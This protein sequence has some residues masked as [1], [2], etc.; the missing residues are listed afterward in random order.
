MADYAPN[1]TPRYRVRYKVG[2]R[3]HSFTWRVQRGL[4]A[5]DAA[6]SLAN[7]ASAFFNALRDI[8]YANFAILGAD[9]AET[10]SDIFL[11]TIAPTVDIGGPSDIGSSTTKFITQ[12]RF[13]A[14]A[15]TGSRYNFSMFGLSLDI[16][17]AT[18][19]DYRISGLENPFLT[20][21]RGAL[22]ELGGEQLVA[23]SGAPLVWKP[24]VN[25]KVNDHW[26]KR[27]RLG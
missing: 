13:E 17:D 6:D 2:G 1:W 9:F 21:A 5:L 4:V 26:V 11:P 25:V 22:T 7:R 15:V 3:N 18:A 27:A 16:D 24:Y 14:R 10:D 19:S 12:Y 8:L 20:A 23:I